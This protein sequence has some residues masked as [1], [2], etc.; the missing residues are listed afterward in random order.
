MLVL[1]RALASQ[2]TATVATVLASSVRAGYLA[3]PAP[4]LPAGSTIIIDE[5]S[6]HLLTDGSGLATATATV[7]GPQPGRY[8]I[9]L[10]DENGSWRVF[11]TRRLT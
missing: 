11:S 9:D 2:S 5:K 1:D 10:V 6:V 4:L 3:H 7:T 8:E